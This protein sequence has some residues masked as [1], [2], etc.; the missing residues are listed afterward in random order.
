MSDILEFIYTGKCQVEI[1][2]FEKFLSDCKYLNIK[3]IGHGYPETYLEKVVVKRLDEVNSMPV[4]SLEENK[5][6]EQPN[7]LING[8]INIETPEE[9][10]GANDEQNE[11][12][13]IL[14]ERKVFDQIN[15]QVIIKLKQDKGAVD[16]NLKHTRPICP[17]CGHTSW[18]NAN[19]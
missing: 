16:I 7:R 15:Q 8:Y 1:L 17:H 6:D 19:L 14:K 18:D 12:K 9:G 4:H 11:E 13:R 3:G 5:E 2:Y 10:N